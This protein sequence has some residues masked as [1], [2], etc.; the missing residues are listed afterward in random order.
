M[1][2]DWQGK[3]FLPYSESDKLVQLEAAIMVQPP[4]GLEVGYVP[5]AIGT[6]YPNESRVDTRPAESVRW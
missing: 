1:H 3:N 5:V 4:A 6:E 2:Q